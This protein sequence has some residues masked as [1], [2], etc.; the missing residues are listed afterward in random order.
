VAADP[1]E[2]ANRTITVR[3]TSGVLARGGSP[4]RPLELFVGN[5]GTA[6]RFIAALVCVGQGSYRLAGTPRMH[7]RPQSALFDALRQLGYRVESST[8]R[9]PA[10]IQ[11]M[12]PRPGASCS[13]RIHESSQFASALLLVAP[14]GKW[15]VTVEGNDSEESPHVSLTEEIVAVFPSAGGT[16]NVE[17]DASSASYF[18]GAG[19]LLARQ[20]AARATNIRVTSWTENSSQIDARFP[21]MLETFPEQISRRGDLGDSIMTAIVLAPFAEA[22]KTFVD[23]ARLRVQECERVQALHVELKK[24]GANVLEEGETL[25]LVPGPL[26]GAEIE[27]YDDHRMAMCFAMLGLAV[28]GIRIRNPEC[29]RKT[30]PNFFQK[31]SQPPPQGLG[32][33]VQGVLS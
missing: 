15:Q 2:S 21:A 8:G 28:P 11:G 29:V 32:V 1:D 26:H 19:W 20:K 31:F 6:A 3:G 13:V 30:F 22:P 14:Y 33:M 24:C 9:L 12:G 4:E 25:R 16:F 5:A 18:W 17:P 7:E 23:L 27:T 10:T